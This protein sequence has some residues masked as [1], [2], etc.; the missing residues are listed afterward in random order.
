VAQGDT[1]VATPLALIGQVDGPQEL[2]FGKIAA[3]AADDSGTIYV[4]DGLSSNV[5]A[6]NIA[7]SHLGTLGREGQGPGEFRYL[8][9]LVLDAEQNLHVRG[10]FRVS[11]FGKS[12]GRPFADSLRRTWAIRGLDNPPNTRSKADGSRYYLPS[13]TYRDFLIRGFFYVVFDALGNTQDTVFVPPLPNPEVSGRATY[14]ID[15]RGNGIG[16]EGVNRAPFEATPSWDITRNGQVLAAAGDQYQLVEVSAAGDTVRVIRYDVPS[17][18]IPARE[19]QDSAR[20]FR[21]RLDS[22]RIPLERMRGMSMRARRAE[23]PTVFPQI[24]AVQVDRA[25]NI[26]LRRWPRG[27]RTETLF[28][29]L[30][31]SGAL[32]S[33]VRIPADILS[34]PAPWVS[35]ALVVGV[36][37][38]PSTQTERVAVFGLSGWPSGMRR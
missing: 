33:T 37:R 11:V 3:V 34:D 27:G 7:G 17:M 15:E 28:D 21:A 18:P 8:R 1:V 16:V 14:P 20:A 26:W 24:L 30:R 5:R 32:W 4:A 36:V 13:Y 23:L 10:A 29:V 35:A 31:P 6:Y 22:I 2:L 25:G 12:Q 9:D 19:L 38:E